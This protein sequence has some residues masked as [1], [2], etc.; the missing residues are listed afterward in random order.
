MMLNSGCQ[1]RR[2]GTMP[3]TQL[4]IADEADFSRRPA[5]RASWTSAKTR[6]L[7]RSTEFNH[8]VSSESFDCCTTPT[9][10]LG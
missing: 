1:E 9:Y 8:T 5:L 3:E 7:N 6:S 10:S 2:F 4:D